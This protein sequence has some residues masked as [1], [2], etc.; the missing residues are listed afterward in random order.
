M[1]AY[2]E[3]NL[4]YD[5]TLSYAD[6]IGFRCGIC[7]EYPVYNVITQERYKLK[8]YPLEIMDCNLWYDDYMNLPICEMLPRCAALK[9]YCRKYQGIFVLLWH[10]SSFVTKWHRDLYENILQA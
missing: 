10:N 6:H 8:E 7:Y 2:E 5:A 1:E 4:E 9:E 3:A